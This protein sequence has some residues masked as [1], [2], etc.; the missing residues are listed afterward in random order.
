MIISIKRE[1]KLK[2]IKHQ[3]QQ[4][5]SYQL[6]KRKLTKMIALAIF[7]IL[8][9][10]INCAVLTKTPIASVSQASHSITDAYPSTTNLF[11]SNIFASENIFAGN[12]SATESIM[13]TT[14]YFFDSGMN[15]TEIIDLTD[16][17]VSSTGF[18]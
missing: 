3:N 12:I 4:L 18:F 8:M 7:F 5:E 6:I 11:T 1:T 14:T 2:K 13:V 16:D 10:F 17:I 15:S 9:Q